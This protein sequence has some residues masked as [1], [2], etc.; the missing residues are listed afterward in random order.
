MNEDLFVLGPMGPHMSQA[1][2]AKPDKAGHITWMEFS[3][4]FEEKHY[5]FKVI[6]YLKTNLFI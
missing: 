2:N 4:L 6:N 5:S 1:Y 3:N